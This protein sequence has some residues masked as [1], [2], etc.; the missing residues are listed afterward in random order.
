MP[1]NE[2]VRAR[3]A[4]AL[5]VVVGSSCVAS[6]A[7]AQTARP[8]LEIVG[9]DTLSSMVALGT[10][11]RIRSGI[12]G[13][14]RE[15][16]VATPPGYEKGTEKFPVLY[17]LDGGQNLLTT[18]SASRAL[19]AAGRM[20]SVIVVAIV[21]TQRDRDFTPKLIRT[22]EPPAELSAVGGA[23]AFLGFVGTELIP[24]VDAK[25]RTQPMRTI[26]G[27]SLGGLV[28]MHALA[29]RPNMFRGYLTLEPSLW[30]DARQ[31]V[32]SVLDSLRVRPS[33]VGRLVAV[34]GTSD[35][36]WKPDWVALGKAA[37]AHFRTSFI[38][39]ENES[40]ENLPYRGI[41]EGLASLFADYMP[42]MR[43]DLSRATLAALDE[44]YGGIS[45]DFGYNVKPPLSALL[46]I[47]NKE[48]NQ[49]RFASAREALA[50][51]DSLYPGS[52]DTRSFRAGVEDAAA[53]AARSG[54]KPVESTVQFRPATK[55]EAAPFVGK[56]DAVVSVDPGTP[57]KGDAVFYQRGDTLMLAFTA[58]GVAID[59]GDLVEPPTPVRVEGA[60]LV[61]DRENAGGGRAVT[62]ARLT[63]DGKIIG[64]ENLAGGRELP[65]G[66]TPPRVTIE[67]TRRRV[68]SLP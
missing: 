1:G 15:V 36:G 16:V 11:L 44:Q 34:E 3:I 54:L 61:W 45:R 31:P 24:A 26:I 63:S 22:S 68:D 32:Q 17:V 42:A 41:Y 30:W 64:E 67:M 48:A 29:T 49:R 8:V 37:P 38:H 43:H 28:A 5:M 19:A 66:F 52:A 62:S 56:W 39:V 33:A 4:S 58:R 51:A 20:P 7:R 47:A 6:A 35:D 10:R 2:I 12:L 18:V 13:E 59:G 55:A 27:H 23:D 25:Y 40:H 60:S 21:N 53:E 9:R 14:T 50:V 46:S 57:M 65:P